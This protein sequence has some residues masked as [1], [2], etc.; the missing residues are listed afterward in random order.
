MQY[1]FTHAWYFAVWSDA[2]GVC[3]ALAVCVR[4]GVDEAGAGAGD[5]ARGAVA[6]CGRE[7]VPVPACAHNAAA[8]THTRAALIRTFFIVLFLADSAE[9]LQPAPHWRHRLRS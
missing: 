2:A 5:D 1:C 8:P 3:V 4:T 7:A 9:R 6:D